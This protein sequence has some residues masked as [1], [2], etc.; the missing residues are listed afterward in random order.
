MTRRSLLLFIAMSV[1]WGLPY[2]FI[3]IA[4]SDLSPVV[5]VFARTAIGALILLPI[6]LV[7]GELR[8][9]I[10]SWL[11]LLAF[12][13]VE[14]GVP[15]VMLASAE[16]K[17]TSSLAGLL[18]AAVPLVGVVIATSLG[19]REHLGLASLSGLLLGVAGVAAIVGFDLRASGW[20]PLVEM[21]VVVVAYAVGPVIVT[22]YLSRLPS[23]GVI[24]VSLAACA[25][26]YAP[27]AAVQWPRSIPPVDTIVSVAVLA[28]VCT[29]V[30]FV[31]FFALIA[32]I[33]PVRATVITYINPA[34]AA[35]LGVVVLHEGFTVGMALGFVLVIA[36]S[37]LATR[38]PRKSP[39]TTAL[40][41]ES[42]SSV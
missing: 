2:L 23:M 14:I 33:G 40:S 35:V 13:T 10:K 17:I 28:V 25:V 18:V 36:G 5:L 26:A 8:G 39:A 34:V 31:L 15:W 41:R 12:A 24:A 30:A 37:V 3:R 6:V 11:P 20:L 19:N 32:A 4:V 42:Q 9:L 29:A 21:A 7:R 22:R 27:V 1:I 16:Q 38:R